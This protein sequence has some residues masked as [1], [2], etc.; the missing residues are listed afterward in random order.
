MKE[1]G[2][3]PS[4]FIFFFFL[5]IIIRKKRIEVDQPEKTFAC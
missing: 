5:I 1:N 2:I 3:S 4:L